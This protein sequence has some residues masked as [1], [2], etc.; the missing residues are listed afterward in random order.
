MGFSF[1]AYGNLHSKWVEEIDFD[2]EMMNHE[3]TRPPLQKIES[4]IGKET[5][6]VYLDPASM[7]TEAAKQFTIKAQW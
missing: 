2:F 5:L 3:N 7:H 6:G 1:D 4:E